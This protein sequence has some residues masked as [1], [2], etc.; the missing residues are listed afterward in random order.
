[1]ADGQFAGQLHRW[2]RRARLPDVLKHCESTTTEETDH[3]ATHQDDSQ[4]AD[5]TIR[6]AS[7]GS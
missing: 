6:R 3:P 4:A 1:M 2:F 5:Q 7:A